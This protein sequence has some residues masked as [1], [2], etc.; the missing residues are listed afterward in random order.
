MQTS[1]LL[2]IKPEFVEKIF[3]GLKRYEF[4]RVIFKS[5]S[6]SKVVVYASSPVQRVVGEFAV[7]GI[8]ELDKQKLWKRTKMHSGIE[9]KYYDEYFDGRQT[10]Y[11]I[12]IEAARRYSVPIKLQRLCKSNRPPQSFMY[13]DGI[14]HPQHL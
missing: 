9:K 6:V 10:A 4:R 7:G 1:I 14:L 12:M 11:A 3:A 8:L 5:K 2:S 13:L